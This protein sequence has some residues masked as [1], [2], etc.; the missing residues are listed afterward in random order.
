MDRRRGKVLIEVKAVHD[1]DDSEVLGAPSAE[2]ILQEA[3]AAVET[4]DGARA[5]F[6]VRRIAH[7]LRKGT[8]V[9]EEA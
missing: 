3:R 7:M 5:M 8:L 1:A 2:W 6:L 9:I 4:D